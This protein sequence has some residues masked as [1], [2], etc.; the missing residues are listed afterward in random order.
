MDE[1]LKPTL[2][3]RLGGEDAVRMVIDEFYERL[4]VDE[5]ISFFFQGI[6]MPLMKLHQIE[7]F[8]IALTGF[9]KGVDVGEIMIETHKRLFQIQGLNKEHF[10]IIGSHLVATLQ[11]NLVPQELINETIGI[12][13][14]LRAAFELGAQLYG[15][16]FQMSDK[17]CHEEKKTDDWTPTGSLSLLEKLG[18]TTAVKAA[19]DEMYF[20][21][22]GDPELSYFFEGVDMKWMK[23]HL[24]SFMKMAFEEA[25]PRDLNVKEFL[26]QKH[27]NLFQDGLSQ[28]HFDMVAKHF[29]DSLSHLC[30]AKTL[31][32]DAVNI[33]APLR[34][35]FVNKSLA[36]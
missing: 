14:P 13:A 5:S 3:S 8:T 35:A 17:D 15:V 30:I 27:C 32:D 24:I 28:N 29:I 36:E 16:G 25:I 18:G 10:D 22:L 34:D 7:F 19:V 6:Q 20:R 23:R 21:I 12:I 1:R 26:R 31:I 4:L 11:N 33:V 2:L 9:P